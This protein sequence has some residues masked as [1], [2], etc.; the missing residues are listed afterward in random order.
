MDVV[1]KETEESVLGPHHLDVEIKDNNLSSNLGLFMQLDEHRNSYG[2]AVVNSFK[3]F[4]KSTT[5]IFRGLGSLF[6]KEG[7]KN[8]GGIIAIGVVTT[9]TL[10]QNGFG[11]FI[12]IWAMISVNLG[13]VNLLPFPGLD[14]WHFLVTIVEGVAHKEIPLKVKNTMSAIGFFILLGLMVL[15]VIKDIIMVV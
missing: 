11:N 9:Q 1:K 12:Y 13:I 14:G 2:E 3:D 10:Q 6:T 5:L 8:V 15:I 4:G 7:W